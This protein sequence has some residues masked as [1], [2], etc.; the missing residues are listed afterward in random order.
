MTKNTNEHRSTRKAP[1][2][3]AV[4][5]S[6][7]RAIIVFLTVCTKDRRL[8]LATESIHARLREAW[9]EA[10]RWLVGR[11]IVMPDHIHLFCAPGT[12]P[13]T[14]VKA[15]AGYWKGLVARALK[16]YGPLVETGGGDEVELVPP[17]AGGR[18]AD[19]G[20]R[21][22]A[23]GRGTSLWQRDCWDTQLRRGESYHAKWMYVRR[24]PVRARF[25]R[26]PEDWPYAGEM[27]VLRWHD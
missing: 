13:R 16:G 10:E 15:W 18:R 12:W 27:N 23:T 21:S 11:Y 9:Q 22:T 17:C 19:G 5:E 24:N 7:N 1:A 26:E 14:S 3:P 20:S 2:H 6:G 4:V 8:V 25:C